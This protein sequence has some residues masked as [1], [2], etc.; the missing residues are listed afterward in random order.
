MF[1]AD[2]SGNGFESVGLFRPNRRR[3]YLRFSNTAGNADA[4]LAWGEPDRLPVGGT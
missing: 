2:W 3:I 1:A 4:E